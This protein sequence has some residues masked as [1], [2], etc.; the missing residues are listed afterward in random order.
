MGFIVEM[1]GHAR[2]NIDCPFCPADGDQATLT[3]RPDT[4]AGVSPLKGG[5]PMSGLSG[6]HVH[7]RS[8]FGGR[9]A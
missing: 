5:T 6:R 2:T 7:R 1:T 3:D 9:D 4:S 8:E